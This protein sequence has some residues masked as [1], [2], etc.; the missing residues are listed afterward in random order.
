MERGTKLG[1]IV[2]AV[3]VVGIATAVRAGGQEPADPGAR[4]LASS[5]TTMSGAITSVN[6]R[7]RSVQVT[8]PDGSIVTMALDPG[9]TISQNGQA[10]P[11]E[12]LRVG[13]TVTIR[14]T[15]H[16]GKNVASAIEVKPAAQPSGSP[17]AAGTPASSSSPVAPGAA[18]P[19][20]SPA[21]PAAGPSGALTLPSSPSS[22]P[23]G[24]MPGSTMSQP[25]G[26]ASPSSSPS[27]S[28]SSPPSSSGTQAR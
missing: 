3:V 28:P 8:S 2:A 10:I 18:S 13:Q 20:A 15:Q 6:L 23:A 26:S 7:A 24:S 17:A 12:Q 4:T 16:N 9:A 22:S 14:Q 25:S 27:A 5:P 21:S 1:W 11:L 19:S